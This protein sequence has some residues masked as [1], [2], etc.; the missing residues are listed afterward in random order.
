MKN[1]GKAFNVKHFVSNK[2]FRLTFRNI[3]LFF[4]LV[5]DEIKNSFAICFY[6]E[7]LNDNQDTK[8]HTDPVEWRNCIYNSENHLLQ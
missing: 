4:A 6:E 1:I 7:E 2:K 3:R 5:F 8:I